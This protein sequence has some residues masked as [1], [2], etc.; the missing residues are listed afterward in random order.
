MEVMKENILKSY[1]S[2]DVKFRREV[3]E[4]LIELEQK[5]DLILNYLIDRK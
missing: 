4:K 3:K 2:P 1:N 5:L